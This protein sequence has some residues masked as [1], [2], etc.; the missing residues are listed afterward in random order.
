M[1]Y[2]F[3]VVLFIALFPFNGRAVATQDSLAL[4]ALYNSTAGDN[5]TFKTNWLNTIGIPVSQWHGIKVVNNRVAEI[6]LFQNNLIGT[7]PPEIGDLTELTSL[8][9]S[10]N[11]LTTGII[12]EMSKLKKL[13]LLQMNSCQISNTIPS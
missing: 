2:L 3:I 5:W 11:K 4:V 8:K 6:T 12:P 13:T 10:S 7:I 9:L 1:R